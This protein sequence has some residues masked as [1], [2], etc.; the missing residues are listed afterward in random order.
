MEG[1]EIT[2]IQQNNSSKWIFNIQDLTTSLHSPTM[3]LFYILP[4]SFLSRSSTNAASSSTTHLHDK[5]NLASQ[6]KKQTT[7]LSHLLSSSSDV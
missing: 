7:P 1:K 5:I 2:I 4:S 3:P 6:A